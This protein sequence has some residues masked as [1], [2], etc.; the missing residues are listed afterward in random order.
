MR[1][2]LV[3]LFALPFIDVWPVY[4]YALLGSVTNSAM[5]FEPILLVLLRNRFLAGV[6]P[7]C[8]VIHVDGRVLLGIVFLVF[9]VEVYSG[10]EGY[11]EEILGLSGGKVVFHQESDLVVP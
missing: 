8:L 9:V 10:S 4:E 6:V 3:V 5:L 2:E 11:S 7:P 1:V